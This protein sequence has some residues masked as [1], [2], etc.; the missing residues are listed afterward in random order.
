MKFKAVVGGGSAGSFAALIKIISTLTTDF[1]MP[2]M[3]VQHLHNSDDGRLALHLATE[4]RLKVIEP[5]D[6]ESIR[7]GCIYIAP[8]NYHMLIEPNHTIALS[9]DEKVN[10]SRPSIDVLFDS[11]ASV[12]GKS[13]IAFLLSGASADGARGMEKIKAAGGLTIAQD[14]AEAEHQVMPKSAIDGGSIDRILKTEDIRQLIARLGGE[15]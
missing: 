1:S 8:A 12:F 5:C 6:K 14:P 4:T 7:G 9:I 11:A 15:L 13:L 10:Y 2:I 3:F